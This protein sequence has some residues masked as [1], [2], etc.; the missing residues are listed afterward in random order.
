MKFGDSN[1][2]I[3]LLILSHW[4]ITGRIILFF[5]MSSA[6]CPSST[7]W[8]LTHSKDVRETTATETSQMCAQGIKIILSEDKKSLN[9]ISGLILST[10]K[11]LTGQKKR[12]LILL[13]KFQIFLSYRGTKVPSC[14]TFLFSI[15]FIVA[16]SLQFF[17]CTYKR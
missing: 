5:Q 17:F 8:R 16:R 2:F 14:S 7:I 15:H 11:K 9:R 10:Q 6:Q 1:Q 12:L 4:I 13:R 3:C